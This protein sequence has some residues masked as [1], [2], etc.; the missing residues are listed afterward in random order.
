MDATVA[1]H[2]PPP[3]R[4]RAAC[5]TG[6]VVVWGGF[7]L[8]LLVAPLIFTSGLALTMLSQIGI[9]IVACLAYNMLLGQGGM[10]SFGHA[11]YSGLGAFVAI[12]ALIGMRRRL[13]ADA[14]EPDSAGRRLRRH[15][16]RRHAR[17]RHD[18]E[19]RHAVRDDHARHR[20]AGVRRC[21]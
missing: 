14:G 15:V 7:A 4:A 8:V 10:L 1:A 9:A 19:G 18:E 5:R 20:R 3:R 2:P 12:H 16:L 11:V 17:L 6:R 21:R 13:V